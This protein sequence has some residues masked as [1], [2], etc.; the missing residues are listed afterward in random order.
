MKVTV[1]GLDHRAQWEDPTG[2]LERLLEQV[3]K[4]KTG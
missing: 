4:V 3:L 2:D 1:L